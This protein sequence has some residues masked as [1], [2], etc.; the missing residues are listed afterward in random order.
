MKFTTTVRLLVVACLL[1][2]LIWFLEWRNAPADIRIQKNAQVLHGSADDVS[3]LSIQRDKFHVE[4]VKTKGTWSIER[5]IKAKADDGQVDRILSA[6][7]SL[8]RVEVITAE[9]CRER[10]LGLKD[11][12]LIDPRIRVVMD[13]RLGHE[14]LMVGS[15]APLGDLVYVKLAGAEEIIATQ[16]RMVDIMPAGLENLRERALLRGTAA[17][18]LRLEI[19]SRGKGFVQ[20]IQAGGKW[21]I[22]QPINA[23][24][25]TAAI[26][27][28][29]DVL[30]ALKAETFVW[31]PLVE[32][33]EE[34]EPATP[35]TTSGQRIELYGLGRDEAQA[36]ISVWGNGSEVGRELILGKPVSPDS[37]TVYAKLGSADAVYTVTNDILSVFSVGV[38]DLRDLTLF[39]IDPSEVKYAVFKDGDKKLVLQRKAGAGW[40]LVEP[41][42]WKADDRV[43]DALLLKITRLAADGFVN[44]LRTNAVEYGLSPPAYTI[45]LAAD[46]PIPATLPENGRTENPIKTSGASVEAGNKN[47]LMIA[48][49]PADDKP[50]FAKFEDDTTIFLLASN[51][52]QS[53]V[54]RLTEPLV[55]RDRT[56]LA[57]KPEKVKRL[58]LL[59]EGREEQVGRDGAGA[60]KAFMPATNQVRG[61]VVQDILCLTANLRASR[62]ES[63]SSKTLAA[64]GLDKAD[65]V[66]TLGLSE[67]TGI[68]KSILM[69]FRARTDG[70][71][72]MIQGED[73]VFVLDNA[74]MERL[75]QALTQ[76]AAPS[77]AKP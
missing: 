52:L 61:D 43:V 28:M 12:G 4:C 15:D 36:R 58:S 24:A 19:Q 50:V 21:V 72:A 34:K 74:Q 10:E 51:A 9:Q 62:I 3:R 8:P 14:E 29:L 26:S 40:M 44:D 37:K 59:K 1:A 16:R 45:Q 57:V 42:P 2:G 39:P 67:D 6:L 55:Y 77:E 49:I 23:R 41:I 30:Y 11:Y 17:G 7:E 75:T 65:I 60:W 47:R 38:N 22:Q 31:D 25:D 32:P 5:P 66:L 76:P 63:D 48:A 73:V 56:M 54:S 71:Y 53:V 68:Q 33:A 70:V 13:G 69:G 18:T 46:A 27:R 64:Y 35:E 20:A